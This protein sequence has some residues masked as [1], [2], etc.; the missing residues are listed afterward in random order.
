MNQEVGWG[1]GPVGKGVVAEPNNLSSIH[2][3]HMWE[4]RTDSLKLYHDR[5][6]NATG[7]IGTHMHNMIYKI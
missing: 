1:N 4:D 3:A 5:H 2:R 6:K 7:C